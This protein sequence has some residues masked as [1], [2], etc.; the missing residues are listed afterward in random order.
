MKKHKISTLNYLANNF[1]P[2]S[3]PKP[4]SYNYCYNK[5]NKYCS[6]DNQSRIVVAF[7]IRI[8]VAFSIRIVVAFSI[9]RL[10]IA[11]NGTTH[12][13][14]SELFFATPF[15]TWCTIPSGISISCDREQGWSSGESTFVPTMWPRFKSRCPRHTS[16]SLL[17]AHY[18]AASFLSRYFGFPLYLT[19]H[20]QIPIRQGMLD[21]EPLCEWVTSK[22]LFYSLIYLKRI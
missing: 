19:R 9:R 1:L 6:D 15:I 4:Y 5:D 3:C 22:S 8:V 13:I 14:S 10:C 2:S 16:F 11:W 18:F 17:L 7:S 20:F 12:E 21:K